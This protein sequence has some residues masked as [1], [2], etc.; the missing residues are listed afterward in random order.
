MTLRR[1][2]LLIAVAFLA[3]C[4]TQGQGGK[5]APPGPL[6]GVVITGVE[7]DPNFS[8]AT[9]AAPCQAAE[10]LIGNAADGQVQGHRL[11][12]LAEECVKRGSDRAMGQALLGYGLQQIGKPREGLQVLKNLLAFSDAA[13]LAANPA[14]ARASVLGYEGRSY[15]YA[16]QRR[17]PAAIDDIDQAIE[18]Q[19][20]PDTRVT[21]AL[22]ARRGFY[23]SLAGNGPAATNSFENA[24]SNWG[25]RQGVAEIAYQRGLGALG[26]AQWDRAAAELAVAFEQSGSAYR[27]TQAMLA[28]YFAEAMA[29][30]ARDGNIVP[31]QVALETR[32]QQTAIA[33]TM[34]PFVSLLLREIGPE[35]ARELAEANPQQNVE[36]SLA[37]AYWYIGIY[38]LLA[39]EADTAQS[40]W[41]EAVSTRVT[42][43]QDLLLSQSMLRRM[44]S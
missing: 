7:S 15:F 18:V 22:L 2:A 6:S 29:G 21:G 5:P 32:A 16:G 17:W 36:A 10:A 27:R 37:Q 26:R 4:Q 1:P 28:A 31:A 33:P 39:G 24:L 35:A 13:R 9:V 20:D 40:A 8:P 42:T 19:P 11:V 43:L 30:L 14:A 3:A 38:H 44:G 41:R 25:D 34:E 12:A 23:Q